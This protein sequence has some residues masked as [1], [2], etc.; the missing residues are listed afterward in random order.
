MVRIP[1]LILIGFGV[2]LL[3]L[4]G[5]PGLAGQTVPSIAFIVLQAGGIALFTALLYSWVSRRQTSSVAHRSDAGKS[6]EKEHQ[7]GLD[8]LTH[9]LDQRG[10]T[11]RLLE[12]M[13][14]GERY[15]NNLAVAIIGIDHLKDVDEKYSH[16]V[17]EKAIVAIAGE[18][19]DTLRMPDRLGRWGHD[20]FLAILP[21]TSLDG[22]R[23]IG[24]RLCEAVARAQFEGRRGVLL[25]LTASIGVT[26]FRLGDDLQ[27]VVSRANRAMKAAKTQ[28]RNR[29]HTDRAA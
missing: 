7:S 3:V 12:L 8:P 22:A 16:A 14:V 19:A 21:E 5:T 6:V 9:L 24:E 2:G 4:V 18:L 20:Q 1:Q 29:V 28:G 11:V 10:L 26:V 15:G 17:A 27:G 25:S 23:H 13:A